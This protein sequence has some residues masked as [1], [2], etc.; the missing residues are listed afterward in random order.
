MGLAA[1]IPQEL[2]EDP[3][4]VQL[5]FEYF[6]LNRDGIVELSS[7]S[8]QVGLGEGHIALLDVHQTGQISFDDFKTFV[9]DV[10]T[11]RKGSAIP[12][13]PTGQGTVLLPAIKEQCECPS[14]KRN[15]SVNIRELSE[16]CNDTD[17]KVLN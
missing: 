2:L 9:Q 7:L 8:Q 1:A 16:P 10:H 5:S 12:D 15:I 14:P 4:V 13:Y 3:D 17:C 6:D 11:K